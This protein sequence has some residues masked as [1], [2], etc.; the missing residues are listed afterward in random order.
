[1]SGQ[2]QTAM[3]SIAIES[4]NPRD[5]Y[6]LLTSLVVP[7]PIA[8]V[9]TLS[10]GG[11]P[12]LAPYSFF[13]AVAGYPPTVMLSVGSRLNGLKDT[14]RNIQ[15]TGEFVVHLVDSQHLRP[16]VLTSAE[17]P[18]HENEFELAGLETVA[19]TDVR[20]PRL[21]SA[22]VAMEA[23]LSQ[24]IPV[25]DTASVLVL[26]QVLRFHIREDLLAADGLAEAHK[27]APMGRLGRDEYAPLGDIV[28]VPR[29]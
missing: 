24:W 18:A 2:Q 13:N 14:G 5:S 23:R 1:M 17:L 20:P 21:A 4:L 26:G 3:H 29:P 22:P 8:W 11:V 19:S 15:E 7:R 6:R 25:K 12:N 16:M 9:S 27:L 10:A 28:R